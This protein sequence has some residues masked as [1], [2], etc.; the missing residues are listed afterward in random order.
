MNLLFLWV[1][2]ARMIK[3]VSDFFS[4][5][6]CFHANRV[7]TSSYPK[8]YFYFLFIV[9]ATFTLFYF[10]FRGGRLDFPNIKPLFGDLLK[11][12]VNRACCHFN[13]DE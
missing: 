13:T 5:V 8:R 9:I 12:H 10:I 3:L 7:E 4:I 1:C 6:L 2:A 11:R